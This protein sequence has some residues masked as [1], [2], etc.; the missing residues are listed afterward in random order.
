[1]KMYMMSKGSW[2]V[3][4]GEE[5]TSAAKKQQAHAL[6]VL[7]LSESQSMHVIDSATARE[8]WRKV[9]AISSLSRHGEPALAQGEVCL[10]FV[11]GIKYE[12]PRHGDGR[13]CDDIKAR[14]LWSK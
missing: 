4:E 7:N 13:P 11:H 8:A 9:G 6:I 1:M 3:L 2:G 12:Q 14:K 5:T 10:V